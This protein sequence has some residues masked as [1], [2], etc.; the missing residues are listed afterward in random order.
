MIPWAP[1]YGVLGSGHLG[2]RTVS[3]TGVAAQSPT[4]VRRTKSAGKS[5]IQHHLHL[6]NMAHKKTELFVEINVYLKFKFKK[7]LAENIAF[8]KR[9]A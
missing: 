3:E 2:S 1:L 7:A 6:C 5:L 4:R 8:T 9:G